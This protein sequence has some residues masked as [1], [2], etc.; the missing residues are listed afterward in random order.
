MKITNY[1]PS[2][3][4]LF[5]RLHKDGIEYLC[6][7]ASSMKVSNK[8]VW[9]SFSIVLNPDKVNQG[10]FV[11]YLTKLGV[12]RNDINDADVHTTN[13]ILKVGTPPVEF[14]RESKHTPTDKFGKE[15]RIFPI[16]FHQ[17]WENKVKMPIKLKGYYLAP[18]QEDLN[19]SYVLSNY[20]SNGTILRKKT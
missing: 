13:I 11:K 15:Q 1:H 18:S 2:S 16:D 3:F 17:L 6:I 12:S 8:I 10:K 19:D 7:G 4:A 14:R 20:L 9:S 5:D